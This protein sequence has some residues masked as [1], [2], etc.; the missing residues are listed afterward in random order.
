M[1]GSQAVARVE[2]RFESEALAR[3][4]G[5]ATQVD[6]PPAYARTAVDGRTV[7]FEASGPGVASV[8]ESVDDF[9]RCAIAADA[10]AKAAVAVKA[11]RARL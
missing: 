3:A 6:D 5:A 10:A 11:A 2:L 4:V 1:E 9:L 7:V 8:R